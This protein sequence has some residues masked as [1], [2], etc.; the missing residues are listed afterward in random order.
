MSSNTIDR[1]HFMKEQD[2]KCNICKRNLIGELCVLDHVIPKGMNGEDNY[3]NI[4][5][6]CVSCNM[7]KTSKDLKDIWKLR[8]KK[9][10]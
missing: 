10:I 7:K 8:K 1:E 6:L 5:L 2:G 9:R 4:Q 3:N